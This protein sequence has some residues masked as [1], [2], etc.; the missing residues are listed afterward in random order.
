MTKAAQLKAK[1]PTS[2][3]ANLRAVERIGT[4][5][6]ESAVW[7]VECTCGARFPAVAHGF[8]IGQTK[9]S[10]CQPCPGDAQ[11]IEILMLLPTTYDALGKKLCA[12]PETVKSR[13][14]T[15]KKN[16]LC[17]TGRWRRPSWAGSFQPVIVAGPGD[18]VPCKLVAGTN[19]DHKRTYRK[20]VKKAVHTAANG[21]K[22]DA[23]YSRHISLYRA[24]Q[25]AK[26]AR[27]EPHGPWAALFTSV[28][29]GGRP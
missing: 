6:S 5:K 26:R 4:T 17:H 3:H 8:R 11:A 7:R 21:G 18:D 22:E 15:M 24:D 25:T 13:V 29:Q 2:P 28:Q 23:R 1:P 9:C 14:R 10:R 27:K 16:G 12:P 19:A 20:R